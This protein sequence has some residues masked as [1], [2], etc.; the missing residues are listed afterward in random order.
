MVKHGLTITSCIYSNGFLTLLNTVHNNTTWQYYSSPMNSIKIQLLAEIFKTS[1]TWVSTM[2]LYRPTEKYNV[3]IQFIYIITPMWRGELVLG[4]RAGIWGEQ[5]EKQQPPAI[6]TL[7]VVCTRKWV[8]RFYVHICNQFR[9]IPIKISLCDRTSTSWQSD[10]RH[11]FVSCLWHCNLE[12]VCQYKYVFWI[13]AHKNPSYKLTPPNILKFV[14]P[15][16]WKI[17]YPMYILTR[18]I[19]LLCF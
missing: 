2:F 13:L 8:A 16:V 5:K 18:N 6:L 19:S 1:E 11:Y 12:K 10:I 15:M 4:G 3:H 17:T 9:S 7:C 14:R